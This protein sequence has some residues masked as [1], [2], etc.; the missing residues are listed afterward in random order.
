MKVEFIGQGL[1]GNGIQV[2]ELIKET[3]MGSD[4]NEF[5]AF[6]AFVSE[7]GVDRVSEGLE[8]FISKEENIVHFYVGVDNKATSKE[9]LEALLELKVPTSIFH[10]RN[11]SVIYHP[12]V[13]L[14]KGKTDFRVITG[15]SNLTLTGLYQNVETSIVVDSK[16]CEGEALLN[17]I[18]SFFLKLIQGDDPNLVVLDNTIIERLHQSG[19]LPSETSQRY[20]G[21]G[22]TDPPRVEDEDRDLIDDLKPIFPGRGVPTTPPRRRE[23]AGAGVTPPAAGTGAGVTPPTAGTGAG[24]TLWFQTGKLTGGSANILD[25][26]LTGKGGGFGGVQ[27]LNP[28]LSPTHHITLRLHGTDYHNNLVIFPQTSSGES[29]G[30]WRLQMRGQSALGQKFTNNTR[31]GQLKDKILI[32]TEISPDH[33]ELTIEPDS[34]LPH[35]IANSSFVEQ[36]PPRGRYYG[37]I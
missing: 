21:E 31:S 10:T 20:T 28:M 9:A 26:S 22:F 4:F 32:L 1:E 23:K 3:L 19:K 29:N 16:N 24:R 8:H 6:V 5:Y 37:V 15:S 18:E 27:L 17:E 2:G 34:R 25:L 13:Y 33:Y 30:T 14:F 7:S 11:K 36:S 12:K 35:Y